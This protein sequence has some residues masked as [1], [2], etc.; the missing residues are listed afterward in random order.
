M[1]VMRERVQLVLECTETNELVRVRH[2]KYAGQYDKTRATIGFVDFMMRMAFEQV[3]PHKSV[4]EVSDSRKN[5][6]QVS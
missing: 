4:A 3:L 1:A 5:S 6:A 2:R